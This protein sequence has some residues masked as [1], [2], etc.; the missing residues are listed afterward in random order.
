MS[1]FIGYVYRYCTLDSDS[2]PSFCIQEGS[3]RLLVFYILQKGNL[4][5][6][7][8]L[9]KIIFVTLK[10]PTH[11]TVFVDIL[12]SPFYLYHLNGVRKTSYCHFQ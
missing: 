7:L 2:N 8:N 4:S 6:H 1:R 3:L 10:K 12:S 11:C 9:V 5:I